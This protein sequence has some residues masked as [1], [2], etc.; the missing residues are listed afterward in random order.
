MATS[1]VIWTGRG[2]EASAEFSLMRPS[3]VR[4]QRADAAEEE[5]YPDHYQTP[6]VGPRQGLDPR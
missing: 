4:A 6:T 1:H 2:A 5:G 3:A